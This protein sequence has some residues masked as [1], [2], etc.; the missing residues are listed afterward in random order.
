MNVYIVIGFQI[1]L[2]CVTCNTN[3]FWSAPKNEHESSVHD[4]IKK[5]FVTEL[6]LIWDIFQLFNYLVI[7]LFIYAFIQ[8]FICLEIKFSSLFFFIQQ[9]A[10]FHFHIKN[11]KLNIKNRQ[12]FPAPINFFCSFLIRLDQKIILHHCLLG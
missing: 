3:W 9:K 1:L 8:L 5:Q 11:L 4:K 2:P 7:Q 12:N 6:F 10:F